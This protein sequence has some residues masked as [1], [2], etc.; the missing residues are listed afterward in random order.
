[1]KLVTNRIP[2]TV[3]LGR[4][5]EASHCNVLTNCCYAARLNVN[6]EGNERQGVSCW[7]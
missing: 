3:R 5:N 6:S 7:A 2:V 4:V 1:M